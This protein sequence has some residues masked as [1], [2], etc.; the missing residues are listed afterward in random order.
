M[1]RKRAVIRAQDKRALLQKCARRKSATQISS[2]QKGANQLGFLGLWYFIIR[3][4]HVYVLLWIPWF[5]IKEYSVFTFTHLKQC[6][7]LVSGLEN[8]GYKVE[9]IHKR[10]SFSNDS[11]NTCYQNYKVCKD[12]A[13]KNFAGI[14]LTLVQLQVVVVVI[15][16]HLVPL[17]N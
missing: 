5:Y 13:W 2:R 14:F 10:P 15:M 3:F 7:F 1:L 8:S 9:N 17:G 12:F 16:S 4:C 11:L 6:I